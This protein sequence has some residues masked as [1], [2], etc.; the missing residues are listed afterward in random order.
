MESNLQT[1][2]QQFSATPPEGVWEKIA[3]ALDADEGYA[4]R[5]HYYEEQPPS[6]VWQHI[7]ENLEE[8]TPA[9][10]V[11]FT[12]RFKKPLR[13]A[14]VAG[15]LAVI[16]VTVTLTVKR[17]EA[18]ALEAGSATTV[19]EKTSTTTV[20]TEAAQPVRNVPSSHE[21]RDNKETAIQ[22]ESDATNQ[23]EKQSIA[24]TEKE[25][26]GETNRSTAVYSSLNNYVVFSDGDGKLRR[27][28]KKLVNL[29]RCKD[30]DGSCQQRLQ[31]LRQKMAAKAMT[32]DFT[33]ILEMLHQLQ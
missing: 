29:V 7:E 28:S 33:G 2:L 15:I 4:Q 31:Q 26:T 11:P 27:V 17:T 23:K 25:N 19:P 18:G 24:V 8:A 12:T 22:K 30:S 13:Y 5:L 32:T 1:K 6:I 16:L 10:V 14:A 21:E 3:D 20:K 9:N